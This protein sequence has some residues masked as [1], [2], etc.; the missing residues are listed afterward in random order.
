MALTTYRSQVAIT[1]TALRKTA[2]EKLVIV[3]S[4]AHAFNLNVLRVELMPDNFVEVDFNN[5][6]PNAAQV[7]HLG[8]TGP[9]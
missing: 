4:H 7:D 9:I 8:L 6:L 2:Y 3:F 5:P 1:T